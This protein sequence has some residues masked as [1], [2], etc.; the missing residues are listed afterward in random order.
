MAYDKEVIEIRYK[1]VVICDKC[2]KEKVLGIGKPL[3]WEDHMNGAL[4]HGYTFTEKGNGFE[5]LCPKC[6]KEGAE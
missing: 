5:N 6:Q 3:T 4:H 2:R 1:T